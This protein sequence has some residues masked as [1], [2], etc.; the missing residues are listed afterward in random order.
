ML[1]NITRTVGRERY[2]ERE[3]SQNDMRGA[4]TNADLAMQ[5][6]WQEYKT[7]DGSVYFH[8]PKLIQSEWQVPA[9]DDN[10]F[11]PGIPDSQRYISRR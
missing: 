7:N 10:I 1:E 9:E 4:P 5:V 6:Q 8:S 3:R 11:E 2:R